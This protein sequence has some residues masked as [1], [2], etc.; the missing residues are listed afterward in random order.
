[1]NQVM[2]VQQDA[3]DEVIKVLEMYEDPKNPEAM[4]KIKTIQALF[5]AS[6]N[7]E[8]NL[9][10][11]EAM[12]PGVRLKFFLFCAKQHF[13]PTSNHV[14]ILGGRP[15]VSIEGRMYKAD[16][17]RDDAGKKTFQGFAEDRVMTAD[18]RAA[19]D[20]P[21]GALGW[22]TRV[23]RAD[24]EFPFLGVGVAGG[25][26]EKNQVARG[27]RLAM[28]AKRA[29]EKALRLAYPLGDASDDEGEIIDAQFTVSK[30]EEPKP[31]EAEP[32]EPKKPEAPAADPMLAQRERFK[33]LNKKFPVIAAAQRAA[34]DAAGAKLANLDL[35]ALTGLNDR[36]EAEA[37]APE[38][39]EAR[40]EIRALR[41]AQPDA[42]G[43]V[44]TRIRGIAPEFDFE[45]ATLAD[46]AS[47]LDDL[48]VEA[49][50]GGAA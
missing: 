31:S 26:A 24:C 42:F 47:F 49:A 37:G 7:A 15:Y 22:I 4:R 20:V 16:G 5:R 27:D 11:G 1:M 36:I 10:W 33:A 34:A 25:S 18:E 40:G 48:R 3:A 6:Q 9:S 30:P 21:E 38:L 35:D 17:H 23:K 2:R 12:S 28:A 50:K 8:N 44:L 43:S 19:Y 13:D 45:R 29:R 39:A 41:I 32:A 46:V 14:Y